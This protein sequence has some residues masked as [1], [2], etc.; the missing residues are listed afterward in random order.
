MDEKQ[1]KER[2]WNR[3]G[4][5]NLNIL[6]LPHT[7]ISVEVGTLDKVMGEVI[8]ELLKSNGGRR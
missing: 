7:I 2:F 8:E 6:K 4:F 5:G 3:L 1:I